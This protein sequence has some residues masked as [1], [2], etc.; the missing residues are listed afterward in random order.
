[1]KN[2]LEAIKD[3]VNAHIVCELELWEVHVLLNIE[4]KCT[5]VQ[6]NNIL[7]IYEEKYKYLNK[8][9]KFYKYDS[10]IIN[11]FMNKNVKIF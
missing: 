11:K 5:N 4:F 3:I 10:D 6:N 1:M 8:I 7:I 2:D 9:N